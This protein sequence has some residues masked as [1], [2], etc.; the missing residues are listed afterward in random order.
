MALFTDGTMARIDDLRAHESAVLDL[1]SA[2]GI[3]VSAKLRLAQGELG[4]E[5]LSFLSLRR[6]GAMRDLSNVVVTDA[7]VSAHAKRTLAMIYRDLYQSRFNDR[8][9]GKWREYVVQSR[10]AMKDLLETGVG[11]SSAPIVKAAPP[12]AGF[13][14]G[15]LLPARTYYVRIAWTRGG[16][17][18]GALSDAV[19]VTVPPGA[20]LTIGAPA[21]P[22]GI[23]GWVAYAGTAAESAMP[24]TETALHPLTVWTE[25]NS[26]LLPN[27]SAWFVQT[28]DFYVE[29]RRELPRG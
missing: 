11:L 3:D 22:D 16:R 26:G 19:S 15:G 28:P 12:V 27:V 14:N 20:K 8:Y 23:S 6:S 5:L 9:E 25:P 21:R 2:E 17:I 18:T 1:A 4:T 7:M 24:Q 13:V 10:N 29:N